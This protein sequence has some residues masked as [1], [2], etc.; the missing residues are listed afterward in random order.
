MKHFKSEFPQA[1]KVIYFDSAATTLKPKKVIDKLYQ[2]YLN[3]YATIH[4]GAYSLS[5]EA[6]EKYY[7]TRQAVAKFINAN[8]DEI[9][10]TKNTTDAINLVARSFG[11][12]FQENDE[13]ILTELEHHSNIVPWQILAKEKKLQIKYI[14][15]NDKNELIIEEF[16]KLLTPNTKLVSLAHI[17]NVTGTVNP[18]AS[19]VQKAHNMNAKVL[20]DGAQAIAHLPVDVKKL[21]ADFYCFSAH[22][23]YGPNGV[24]VLYG[25]Y[26]LLEKMPPAVYGGDMIEKVSFE[27]AIFQKPPYRFEAGTP[28][29]AEIIAFK[30]S[31]D[32]L[33]SIGMANIQKQ[34][35]DLFSYLHQEMIKISDIVLPIGMPSQQAS[36]ISFTHNHLHPLDLA[37]FLD[38]KKIAIRTGKLCAEPL[39]QK[40]NVTS[41]CRASL[42]IY[43]TVEDIDNFIQAI[44]EISSKLSSIIR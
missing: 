15:V 19:I 31:I 30:E 25:K 5:V 40:L 9:I 10:F 27:S 11:S 23:A 42:G 38:L 43:N 4:R 1:D 22:K 28:A 12:L 39:M 17:A 29:I 14:P 24:G 18:I 36:I 44:Q 33:S 13:I 21:D 26:E 37:T 6:S 34:E 2:F 3:E 8:T 16:E 20:V 35:N 7:N 41:L 32:F